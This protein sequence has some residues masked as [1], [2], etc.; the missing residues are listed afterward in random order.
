MTQSKKKIVRCTI[1][2]RCVENI[3]YGKI[4]MQFIEK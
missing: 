4:K 1:H 2:I 3:F